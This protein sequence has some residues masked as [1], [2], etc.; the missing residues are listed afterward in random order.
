MGFLC[1]G[2]DGGSD[3]C[4]LIRN[5]VQKILNGNNDVKILDVACGTGLVGHMVNSSG[6]RGG[7]GGMAVRGICSKPIGH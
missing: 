3:R 7:W 2:E 5:F 4:Q 1:G 6:D